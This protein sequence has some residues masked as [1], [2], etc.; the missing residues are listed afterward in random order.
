MAKSNPIY[1]ED[2]EA[3]LRLYQKYLNWKYE[4]MEKNFKKLPTDVIERI[5]DGTDIH[6]KEN[7]LFGSFGFNHVE[8][9][10]NALDYYCDK[11]Y[12][13]DLVEFLA[14]VG[15]KVNEKKIGVRVKK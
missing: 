13:G 6:K 7:D 1:Q 5:F 15:H 12:D 3:F 2:V 4:R 8:K 9:I 11:M 14:K 10:A